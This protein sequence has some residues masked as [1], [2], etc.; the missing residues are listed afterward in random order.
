MAKPIKQ[1]PGIIAGDEQQDAQHHEQLDA[2]QRHADAH[3]GFQRNRV[4]GVRFP[5]ETRKCGARI[6]KSIDA[7]SEPGDSVASADAYEAED[8]NDGNL[9]GGEMLEE[10]KVNHHD[11]ADEDLENEDE[12]ALC[13]QIGLAGLVDQLGNFTHGFVN[14][15]IL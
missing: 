7:D 11:D 6:G 13:N 5:L 3:A 2:D 14:R 9:L 12:L 1:L 10:P 8:Q 15:Q 4:A